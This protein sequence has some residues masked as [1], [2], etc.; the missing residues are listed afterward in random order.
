MSRIK[1]LY[2]YLIALPVLLVVT[3]LCALIT[4]ICIPWKNS[5][6]LHTIQATWAKLFCWLYF[7]PV[8]VEGEQYVQKGQSYVFVSNHQSFFDTFVI[9]GWL[10]VVFKWLMKKEISRIPMVGAAC[11]AAGH[12]AVDRTHAKAAAES[13]H[14]VKEQLKEGVSTVIFPEGTRTHDGQ[15]ARFKRGAFQIAWEL[16]LPV[17]PI[18]LD[19]CYEVMNRYAK[20]VTRHPV[21][22]TILPPI[23]LHQ[24][25]TMEEAIEVVRETMV[26]AGE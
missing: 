9:Y 15:I 8:H 11:K 23:D 10:P 13:L 17:I 25:T 1:V 22:M 19:G 3:V 5:W 14:A 24:Y 6:W 12:I 21:K 16:N 7:I 4:I 26:R 2:Q 18:R 20:T